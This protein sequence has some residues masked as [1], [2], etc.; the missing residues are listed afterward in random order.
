MARCQVQDGRGPGP[1]TRQVCVGGLA[2]AADAMRM[3]GGLT[4][5]A[6]FERV[7]PIAVKLLLVLEARPERGRGVAVQRRVRGVNA[8][9]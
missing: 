6:A 3:R 8:F 2:D 9:I 7:L 4:R 5:A 1:R